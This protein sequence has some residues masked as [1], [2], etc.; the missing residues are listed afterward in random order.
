M[1]ISIVEGQSRVP[2]APES[3][4]RVF[5]GCV[6]PFKLPEMLRDEYNCRKS[7][8]VL[9]IYFPAISDGL[10]PKMIER[11]RRIMGVGKK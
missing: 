4:A 8:I 10:R 9:A 2:N 6:L 3:A 7:W 11:C 5:D 1:F